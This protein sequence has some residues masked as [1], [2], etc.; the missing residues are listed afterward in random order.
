M[1]DKAQIT[2][3]QQGIA[4][5]EGPMLS[6]YLD[7]N[8]GKPENARNA[9]TL[10]AKDAMKVL[11]APAAVCQRVLDYLATHNPSGRTL[12]LFAGE[13]FLEDYTLQV[14][15]PLQG[16]SQGVEAKWGAPH[17]TPLLFA[18]D[19]HARTGVVR[20][21]QEHLQYFEVFLGEIEEVADAFRVLPVGE[22]RKM[23]EDKVGGSSGSGGVKGGGGL[24]AR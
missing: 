7:V 6:L 3:I 16:E 1:L 19:Q 15:L 2:R 11:G 10:R 17:L 23:G 4:N 21:D 13:D 22:W 8:T 12:A 9:F 24:M 5:R 14:D 20:L 18:L